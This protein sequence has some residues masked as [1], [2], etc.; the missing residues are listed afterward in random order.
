MI[1]MRIGSAR[2]KCS[3]IGGGSA[4][5]QNNRK[6]RLLHRKMN[7]EATYNGEEQCEQ[8][9]ER[10]FDGHVEKRGQEGGYDEIDHD[11][12]KLQGEKK[13]TWIRK[14]E[15]SRNFTQKIQRLSSKKMNFF[16]S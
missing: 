6:Y 2:T 14:R 11:E 9:V 4:R 12:F 10:P 7:P 3:S 15:I 1:S 5:E 8:I 13:K 16:E